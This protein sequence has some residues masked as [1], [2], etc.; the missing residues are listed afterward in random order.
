MI[1][2]RRQIT[3]QP[4][5]LRWARERAGLTAEELAKKFPVKPERVKEWEETGKISIAQA[6]KLAAKTYTPL[7]YL[8]LL[9]PPDESLPIP[10]FRTRSGEVPA[11]PSPNLLDTVYQMQ[12]RQNWMRDDLVE[13]GAVP[14]DFIGAYN[15]T[16]SH[17]EVAAGMRAALGLDAE[18]AEER[19]SW[20]DALSFLR[21]RLDEVGVLVTFSGIVGNSYN[22]KLDPAEFQGFALVDEYAPLVFVNSRDFIAA[23]MFTL[24][25]EVAHLF[26][27]EPGLSVFERLH[28]RADHAAERFCDQTAAEF[29]VPQSE[30]RSYWP[31]AVL[32]TEPFQAIARKFK[33]SAI[34]A[35]RRALD[36]AL[37]ER[38]TFFD[39]YDSYAGEQRKILQTRSKD[40]GHF[41][42][43]QKWRVGPRFGCWC[44]RAAKAGR[45]PYLEAYRLTGLKGDT[46]EKIPEKLGVL[47]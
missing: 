40:S 22:R 42:N 35:A 7:G 12:H 25:H 19:S 18:W 47:V 11:R 43:T 37:I 2:R 1:N 27:G 9:E 36:L 30:L 28:P 39:F 31:A 26:L 6:D 45:L 44:Y 16:D 24:A 38:S 29:L 33:V 34:V 17:A 8:Y 10:D 20:R 13:G 3:L 46:F 32:A 4:E 21:N 15:L 5:V 23:Q 14:L 41:W